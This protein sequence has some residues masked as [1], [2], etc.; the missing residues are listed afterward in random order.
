MAEIRSLTALRGVA[1]IW[2]VLHHFWPQTDS[3][4]PYLIS[5][6]YL[7]VDL[8][9][10]LSGIVLCLVYK[11]QLR[12]GQFDIKCFALKRFARLYPV[13][14]VTLILAALI[15]SLGPL[16]GFRCRA[17]PYD[18]G[19]M[20]LLHLTLT[21]AWGL[22]ET[23]GLNYPSW[24]VSAE[25]FA[26]LLFP[27]LGFLVLK[28]NLA[29]GWSLAFLAL[30]IIGIEWYWPATLRTETDTLAFTRM[31]SDFG[32]LRIL[33]EF[34]LGIALAK[35]LDK[36]RLGGFW[37]LGGVVLIATG[38]IA[39]F[40]AITLLGFAVLLAGCAITNPRTGWVSQKL[41]EISYSIYMIHA[42]VQIVGFKLIETTFGY[43]DSTVPVAYLL[44]MVGL[45]VLCATA[46]HYGCERPARRWLLSLSKIEFGESKAE[47]SAPM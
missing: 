30:Y 17:L 2:I 47:R 27:I 35:D 8:F 28:T 24:S 25:A 40:D 18:L 20:A 23:G 31:E 37:I 36:I 43:D 32:A 39:N 29:I 19:Q 13:H 14:L 44:P 7:A 34:I 26:Y 4:T 1:A 3:Q 42:L 46:L 9:F 15:L 11:D 33:P 5:K 16:L 6:G 22:T 12:T 41:G 10:I 45:T 38:L 21:H